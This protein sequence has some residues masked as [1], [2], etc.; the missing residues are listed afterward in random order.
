MSAKNANPSI[1]ITEHAELVGKPAPVGAAPGAVPVVAGAEA[2]TTQSQSITADSNRPAS[3]GK[4][5]RQLSRNSIAPTLTTGTFQ[6][7]AD[8][9]SAYNSKKKTIDDLTGK[10]VDKANEAKQA[11]DDI[12]P[13]LADMQSLL[14]K[15]GTNHH[16]VIAA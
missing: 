7:V 3:N 13:H 2:T 6:S 9:L 10:F 5:T 4:V 16:L 11:Q 12:L 15:K 8:F 1:L 14:S